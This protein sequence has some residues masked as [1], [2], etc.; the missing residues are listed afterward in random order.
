LAEYI[1]KPKLSLAIAAQLA[2][3]LLGCGGGGGGGTT[4]AGPSV[5][6]SIATQPTNQQVVVGQTATF[7]VTATGTAPL[8]YQWQKSG[9]PIPG[10][11]ASTYTTPATTAADNGSGFLVVVSNALG[12]M[13]SNTAKLIVATG[14][15]MA[16]GTDVT[17]YKNDLNRS[18]Q[19]LSESA[20]TLS[21]VAAATFGLLRTLPVDGK[22]D[23]Q[24]LY[25]SKLGF[26]AG[27]YN[28]VFVATE[29]DSVYAFDS[30]SGAI[31][32]H[33]SLLGTGESPSDDRGCGQV[34]P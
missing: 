21:T 26:S 17:T 2:A 31:L 34:T 29:H 20:L 18:G 13:S 3:M 22:V 9:T 5:A 32:W 30:D 27:S 1:M 10:A 28:T 15:P 19:N 25:L 4:G 12:S 16:Q 23:A 14:T 8:S 7:A 33:V 11:T 6:P 24:P